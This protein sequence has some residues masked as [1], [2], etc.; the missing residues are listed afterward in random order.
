MSSVATLDESRPTAARFRP[1]N[2]R[3]DERMGE[4]NDFFRTL[5]WPAVERLLRPRIGDHVLDAACGNGL[6]A[7]LL[8]ETGA[9]V[10]AVDFSEQ[11]IQ[12]AR[13]HARASQ[14]DYRIL[15]LT[16]FNALI[17]LGEAQFDAALCNMALMDLADL[18]PQCA[19]A[20]EHP[21]GASALSWSGKFSEIPP[22]LVGR[23][24]RT[25]V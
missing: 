20:S 21:G 23:L 6:T 8:T 12:R 1:E 25:L 17:A 2:V 15:D 24:R 19:F 3:W 9:R 22:V 14:I 7:R 4:G 13:S 10:I 11:L 5:V 16:D 18:N